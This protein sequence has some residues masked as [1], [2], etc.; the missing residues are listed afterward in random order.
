M[1]VAIGLFVVLPAPVLAAPTSAERALLRRINGARA[2]HHLRPLRLRSALGA[3][4]VV[5]TRYLIHIQQL[6]HEA[7]D[8]SSPDVRIRRVLN[9]S[10]TGETLALAESVG[11]L[12][13]AWMNSPPHR[14]ILLARNLK[15]IGLGVRSGR[16]QGYNVRYATADLGG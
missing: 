10:T 4:A 5:H 3:I 13:T 15:Y 11:A 12:F 1:V 2:A 6:R 9:V 16:F 14:A 7:A 8:G